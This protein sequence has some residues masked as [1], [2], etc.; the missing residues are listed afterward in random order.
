MNT[1]ECTNGF[2]KNATGSCVSKCDFNCINGFCAGPNHCECYDGLELIADDE[3]G[4]DLSLRRSYC[5]QLCTNGK[6]VDGA[7]ECFDGYF[8]VNEILCKKVKLS[9][10]SDSDSDCQMNLEA[11]WLIIALCLLL[12]FLLR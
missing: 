11:S 8:N 2:E 4:V 10:R 9:R 1:C 12:N 7:C 3:C 5:S 6:C